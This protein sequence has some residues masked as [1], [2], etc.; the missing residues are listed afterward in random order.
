MLPSGPR[1][2][3]VPPKWHGEGRAVEVDRVSID[4]NPVD[5]T[6]HQLP[7]E[8]RPTIPQESGLPVDLGLDVC[9][10]LLGELE[11]GSRILAQAQGD[12]LQ[13]ESPMRDRREQEW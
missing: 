5:C 11:D 2:G 4:H 13:C 3:D 10:R 9:L 1:D 12:V 6:R 8:W 7:I